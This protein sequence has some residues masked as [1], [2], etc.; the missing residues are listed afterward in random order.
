MSP[1]L[2]VIDRRADAAKYDLVIEPRIASFR[3]RIPLIAPFTAETIVSLELGLVVY[4][5]GRPVWERTYRVPDVKGPVYTAS[6]GKSGSYGS[7]AQAT[8]ESLATALRM[9]VRDFTRDPSLRAAV[10][11]IAPRP[12]RAAA[13]AAPPPRPTPVLSKPVARPVG[14]SFK[15]GPQRPYDVAV[16]IGNADYGTQGKDIP[17][18]IPAIADAQ[19]IR[20]YVIQALGISEDNILYLENAT[21]SG[22]LA[23]FGNRTDYRGQL[24]NYVKPGR[25]RVFV[26]F[27]GHGAPGGEDGGSYLVPTDSQASMIKL[28]GYPLSTLYRNLSKIPAA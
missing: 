12:S 9:S 2:A 25:S 1:G 27:S 16:I 22:M 6:L 4:G 20:R 15:K 11:G 8:N 26:Y 13:K 24:F 10:S 5:G 3:Y 21:Q 23:V 17:D 7:L 14:V 28:N 19:G 18:V